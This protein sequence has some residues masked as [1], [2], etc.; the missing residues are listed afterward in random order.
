MENEAKQTH[1]QKIF[2][3]RNVESPILP[4]PCMEVYPEK[5]FNF[6]SSILFLT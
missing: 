2:L 1:I 5:S 3:R 6:A 4:I